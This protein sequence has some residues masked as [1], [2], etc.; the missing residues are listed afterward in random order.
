MAQL[1]K[2]VFVGAVIADVDREHVVA[3][4]EAQRG[5]QVQQRLALVPGN[6]GSELEHLAAACDSDIVA[7]PRRDG[8]DERDY[9]RLRYCKSGIAIK[10]LLRSLLL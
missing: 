10:A 1:D 9:L 3:A 8:V 4:A 5:E 2:R 7:V 6:L